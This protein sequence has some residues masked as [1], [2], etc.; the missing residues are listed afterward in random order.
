MNTKATSHYATAF[1]ERFDLRLPL[2]Q[3]PMVGAT[4]TA[5]VVASSN[6]GALGCLGAGAMTPEKIAAEVAEI[7]ASTS[8]AFGVNLF[9][10]EPASPDDATAQ[11]LD[12]TPPVSDIPRPRVLM[13]NP[14]LASSFVTQLYTRR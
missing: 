13:S 8:R 14:A 1:A 10:L 4:T 12:V 2:V 7:R 9:V 5:L 11:V 6:A 3:A